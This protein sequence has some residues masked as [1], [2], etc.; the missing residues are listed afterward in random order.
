MRLAQGTRVEGGVNSKK[1]IVPPIGTLK[2]CPSHFQIQRELEIKINAERGPSCI[3]SSSHK[4]TSFYKVGGGGVWFTILQKQPP[5]G[6]V[7]LGWAS[8]A[9]GEEP[10]DHYISPPLNLATTQEGSIMKSSLE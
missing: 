2:P 10:T 7:G 1:N 6:W 9:T 8:G 4:P 5:N 3:L